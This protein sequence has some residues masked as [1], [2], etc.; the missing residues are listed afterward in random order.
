MFLVGSVGSYMILRFYIRSYHFY[1]YSAIL[2]VLVIWNRKIVRSY[3]P[4]RDFNNHEYK[5]NY[6]FVSIYIFLFHHEI[7]D[8]T[9][10]YK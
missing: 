1:D 9:P 7:I 6:K 10:I 2:N 8:V 3:D 5:C 4:N